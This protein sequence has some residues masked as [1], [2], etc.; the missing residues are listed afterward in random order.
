MTAAALTTAAALLAL[1]GCGAATPAAT[2]APRPAVTVAAVASTTAASTTAA[3]NTPATVTTTA[4]GSVSGMPD[5]MIVQIGVD[6]TAAHVATALRA[7]DA[8]S[9][10]VQA[11][12][13]SHGVAVADIQT[14]Q[15]SLYP[16]EGRSGR[17]TG[18]Q[19]TDVVTATIHDLATAGTVL[20]AALAA[21][22]DAG[23]LDDVSFS[24][25]DDNSLLARARRQ[26]MVAAR[27]DAAQLAA[28]AGLRVV[29]LRSVVDGDSQGQ[30]EPMTSSAGSASGADASVP[31][32]PGTQQ[33]TDQVTAVWNLG[34]DQ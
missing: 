6:N 27:A 34:P 32:Q 12:L 20:D 29:G 26:A 23:R 14:A 31:V 22:G 9:A 24:I 7:N 1:T 8:R 18:Y 10:A 17:V 3:S 33:T 25:A 21:A 16:Q 30:A 28:A 4:T 19:V 5:V 2:R 11:S 15:L 13:V